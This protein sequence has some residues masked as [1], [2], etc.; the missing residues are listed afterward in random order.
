MEKFCLELI[1]KRG[2]V[3]DSFVHDY[4]WD[5]EKLVWRF[6]EGYPNGFQPFFDLIDRHHS[7]FGIWYSPW[8]GY[9]GKNIRVQEGN[10]HGLELYTTPTAKARVDFSMTGSRYYNHILASCLGMLY[11]QKVNYFKFDRFGFSLTPAGKQENIDRCRS[12]VEGVWQLMKEIRQ[13]DPS[14]FINPSSGTW[15]SPFWLLEGD[16]IWRGGYDT[17]YAGNKGSLRQQ[18]ITFRDA[19]VYDL[20]HNRGPLYPI[21]SLM[22]HG[23]EV[24]KG[25]RITTFNAQDM[26]D[27]IRAFFATGVN[28]QELYISPELLDKRHWDT[29]AECA[30]WARANSRTLADVHWI[31]GDPAKSEVY[32]RAAWTPKKSILTLRNPSDKTVSID[33]DAE[34]IFELPDGVPSVY[35]MKSP[36]VRDAKRPAV[37]LTAGKPFS[38]QLEPFEVVILEEVKRGGK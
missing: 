5:D 29:L 33:L 24:N 4:G 17:G 15:P 19:G 11:G 13:A 35:V 28:L 32:G 9:P 18:W 10:R 37:I 26:D 22:I 7:H 1:D 6:H 14:V 23:I 38:M 2:V 30:K 25:G 20:V 34:K 8:G 16:S 31:G 12:E 27:E 36:L 21:S 3:F